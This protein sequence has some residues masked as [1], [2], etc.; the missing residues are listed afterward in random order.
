M[1]NKQSQND[2]RQSYKLYRENHRKLESR[3]DNRTKLN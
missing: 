2:I 3:I 1:D